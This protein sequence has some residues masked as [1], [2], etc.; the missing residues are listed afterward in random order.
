M[1]ATNSEHIKD[2]VKIAL[3]VGSVLSLI[4]QYDVILDWDFQIKDV[5]RIAFNYLVPFSVAS[6]SRMMY[7]RKEEKRTLK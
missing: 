6:V 5:L 3:V 2:A 1:G 7:I 4:N